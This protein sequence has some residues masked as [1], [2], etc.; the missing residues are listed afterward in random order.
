MGGG[1]Y[2]LFEAYFALARGAAAHWMLQG[3]YRLFVSKLVG[4]S[5]G[6]R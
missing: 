1:G 6:R 4:Y 3:L 5:K 2:E